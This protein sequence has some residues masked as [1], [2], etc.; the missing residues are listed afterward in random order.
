MRLRPAPIYSA[1][2]S[3]P[4]NPFDGEGTRPTESNNNFTQKVESF[5]GKGTRPTTASAKNIFTRKWHHSRRTTI[6]VGWE[7]SKAKHKPTGDALI[8]HASSALIYSAP[9][10]VPSNPFD[11]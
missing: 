3:V 2:N 7:A 9:N 11:G 5:E 6:P 4:S 10:S 8:E 1:P